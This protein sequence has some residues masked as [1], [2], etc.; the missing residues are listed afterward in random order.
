MLRLV[1]FLMPRIDVRRI[2][3]SR[4][5]WRVEREN[6][7]LSHP[8]LDP[9]YYSLF[10]QLI[11]GSTITCLLS[12]KNIH[13]ELPRP[14]IIIS[15]HTLW[16]PLNVCVCSNTNPLHYHGSRLGCKTNGHSRSTLQRA[17][18]VVILQTSI[19]GIKNFIKRNSLSGVNCNY[20]HEWIFGLPL[21]LKQ[22]WLNLIFIPPILDWKPINWSQYGNYK[23]YRFT[24]YR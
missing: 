12:I 3:T 10:Q 4:A 18:L 8:N 11:S 2:T 16:T 17:L 14:L 19:C 20:L 21:N 24:P 9:W 1:K 7:L 5:L 23:T 22:F 13:K 15:W 6:P